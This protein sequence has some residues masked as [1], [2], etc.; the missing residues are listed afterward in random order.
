MALNRTL[1]RC[2]RRVLL[3]IICIIQNNNNIFAA[4][5]HLVALLLYLVSGLV[6]EKEESERIIYLGP[7]T[8]AFERWFGGF[9][10]RYGLV[11]SVSI[12]G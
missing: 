5:S 11:C 6:C 7:A 12:R 9:R 10:F 4:L 1:T 3:G 2:N 8:A